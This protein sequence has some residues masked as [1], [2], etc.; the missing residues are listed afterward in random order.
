MSGVELQKAIEKIS[1]KAEI[2]LLAGA[3]FLAQKRVRHSRLNVLGL[4]LNGFF[5]GMN[6]RRIQVID[7]AG[8]KFLNSLTKKRSYENLSSIFS[9]PVPALILTGGT[10]LTKEIENLARANGIPVLGTSLSR[11][12]FVR[13]MEEELEKL[14]APRVD[15]RGTM[16]EV[17]GVGVLIEGKSNVGKSECAIDLLNKGHRLVGD[18]IVDVTRRGSEVLLARGKYPIAQRMELRG[19]GIVDIRALMGISAVKDIQKIQLIVGLERWREDKNYERLGLEEKK[20]EILGV[21]VAYVEIP[22]APGRNTAILVETAALN[23]R[24]RRMGIVPARQLDME[25][26]ESFK[27]AP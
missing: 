26:L 19:I 2:K 6:A 10:L 5:E 16:L 14:L 17:F 15:V 22:V 18:D 13:I 1:F 8:F 9:N 3:Q 12:K 4:E 27:D 20:K 21:K 24:L 23:Y 25:V 11:W 7:R